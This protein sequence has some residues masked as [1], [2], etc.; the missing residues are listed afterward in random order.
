M[1]EIKIPE[2]YQSDKNL[3]KTQ[4]L[5]KE[6]K[7]FFQINLSNNLNLKR[8]SAPLFVE[9]STGL[10][11]NLSG[12]EEPVKFTLPE[13]NN[14]KME[15]V[16][17]L[18]KWKRYAL[19]EYNF[20]MYEGLYT[21]MNAIRR[22]EVPDNTHSFYV[23]QWDWE[24]VIEPSDRNVDYLK[25]TVITIFNTLRA[26]DEYLCHLIPKRVKL[27]PNNIKFMTSQELIDEFPEC[28]DSKEREKAACKKYKAIFLMQI[29]KVLSNGE[30]HDLRSP[31]YDDWNLNG[32]ILV[33]NPVLDDQLELSSMG[34]RVDAK[35]LKEQLKISDCEE[36][37]NY[38]YHKL[39]VNNEL[40]QTIGG[41]IGQSRL[42]MF[43][44]Q[45]AHIGEVQVSYWPDEMREE[46]KKNS[47]ILL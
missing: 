8:V 20:A 38:K 31:D 13:A 45:K 35:T 22:C 43:F 29:G 36:R 12:V 27:L 7:D 41:G 2:N 47:V 30:V 26:L 15:I 39:L 1:Q 40:P 18:A 14:E 34:I 16:H 6:I 37:L 5:I 10:N 33:Y 19:K 32:D 28:K 24:K 44:L 4:M 46:L 17:S 25:A 23:D 21:D 11:D 3:Y 9:N 42:C